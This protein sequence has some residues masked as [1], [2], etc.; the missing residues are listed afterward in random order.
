MRSFF[1]GR[2]FDLVAAWSEN[3]IAKLKQVLLK[4]LVDNKYLDNNKSE[5]LNP[6]LISDILE[7]EIRRNNDIIAL[8]AFNCLQ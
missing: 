1:S 8:K 7:Q 3:T 5:K 6:V 2:T 4:L